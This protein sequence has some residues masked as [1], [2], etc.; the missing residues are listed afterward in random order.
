MPIS[1]LILSIDFDVLGTRYFGEQLAV[2]I[3]ILLFLIGTMGVIIFGLIVISRVFI[4]S[5]T[6]VTHA[7]FAWFLPSVSPHL[8]IAVAG[9]ELIGRYKYSPM[10]DYLFIISMIGIGIGLFLYIFVGS[11]VY[12]RYVYHEIHTQNLASTFF[13]GI[14]PPAI[15]TIILAKINTNIG[16]IDFIS[17]PT[18]ISSLAKF[19]SIISWGFAFW[20]FIISIIVISHHIANKELKYALS[21][22]AFT[23]PI[24]N[25]TVA[26][27][28][29]ESMFPISIFNICLHLFIIILLV[30]WCIVTY[31]TIKSVII[32]DS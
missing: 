15:I 14:V 18:V 11:T 13:I 25:L 30:V 27:A 19:G 10:S 5:N 28:C 17:D 8:L 4:G 2:L 16:Y 1:M 7:N 24:A 31:N 20:W 9:F 23:F 26:T 12:H 32:T 21:W 6:E 29:I 3:S 22:W